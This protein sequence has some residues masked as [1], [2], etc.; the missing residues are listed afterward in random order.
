MRPG[1]GGQARAPR[2]EDE[3][4]L[5]HV[6]GGGEDERARG[7]R[8]APSRRG[9]AR[10]AARRSR[11]R[12]RGRR[13][14]PPGRTAWRCRYSMRVSHAPLARAPAMKAITAVTGTRR[15]RTSGSMLARPGSPSW[16]SSSQSTS[17]G[18]DARGDPEIGEQEHATP[19]AP[20]PM[21][22][23]AP[24]GQDGGEDLRRSRPPGTTASPCRAGRPGRRCPRMRNARG[25]RGTRRP[26]RGA[27][28]AVPARR[29]V[30]V[31]RSRHGY[32]ARSMGGRA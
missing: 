13:A 7:Q 26:A 17:G 8:D 10:T 29:A 23:P 21:H 9:G 14:G 12:D 2:G 27:D 28:R 4:P 6:H 3:A 1:G 19:P 11:T 15:R 18:A 16:S 25:R 22:E 20:S 31:I 30:C 24:E 32:R 5:E